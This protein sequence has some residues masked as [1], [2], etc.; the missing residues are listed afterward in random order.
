MIKSMKMEEV[1]TLNLQPMKS[2][3][4][5]KCKPF[6]I[7]KF[8]AKKLI[9]NKPGIILQREEKKSLMGKNLSN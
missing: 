8:S 6:L 1:R 5:E 4:N 2:I 9:I 7:T 3:L